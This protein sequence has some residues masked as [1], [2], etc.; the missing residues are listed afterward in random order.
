VVAKAYHINSNLYHYAGNNPVK[1]TD[2]TGEFAV[3]IPLIPIA[4][5]GIKDAAV[6][7][8]TALSVLILGNLATDIINDEQQGEPENQKAED[9]KEQLESNAQSVTPNP[10]PPDED[11]NDNKKN[12]KNSKSNEK[13]APEKTAKNMAKQIERDLGKDARREFHD[14]KQGGD[15]TL[16]QLKEDAS[17]LYREYGK[18][19]PRWMSDEF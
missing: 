3:A 2:P 5:E 4:I 16:R 14:A 19:V 13:P 6:I 11:P 17:Q 9:A 15:R 1:Y 10:I 18:E 12:N 8:G 7:V